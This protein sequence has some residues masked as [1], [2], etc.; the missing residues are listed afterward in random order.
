MA[1]SAGGCFIEIFKFRDP[2]VS[3]HGLISTAR[4]GL[5]GLEPGYQYFS[6]RLRSRPIAGQVHTTNP[7]P[8]FEN[9]LFHPSFEDQICIIWVDVMEPSGH[10][11][12]HTL[13]VHI[14]VFLGLDTSVSAYPLVPWYIW[15]PKNSRWSL[16]EWTYH[17]SSS[18][19]LRVV[20]MKPSPLESDAGITENT[21]YALRLRDFNLYA[22]STVVGDA[23]E[24]WRV[25]RDVTEPLR[26]PAGTMFVQDVVSQL[27]YR[28]VMTE[29]LFDLAEV[30]M[31]GN[32]IVLLKV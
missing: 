21:K 14:R 18:Y 30:M 7:I 20:D 8:S 23:S 10:I 15:G 28:E 25:S 29:A 4:F 24:D 31:D 2:A 12:M 5:P 13:F 6:I 19:G 27:P 9:S 26:I 17:R 1:T 32:Q 22:L 11:P 16:F 3:D